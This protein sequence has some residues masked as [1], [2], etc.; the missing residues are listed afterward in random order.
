MLQALP[1]KNGTGITIYG[2]YGDL[3]LLYDT[4]H[5]ISESL[6]LDHS[7]QKGQHQLLMNFAYEV[8]K[9][10]S[11]QRLTDNITFEGDDQKLTHYGFNIV[12]TDILIF[13]S[14]LRYNAGYSRTEKPHQAMLYLLEYSV[15]QALYE[16][17]STGA[18]LIKDYI[19]QRINVMNEYVFIIYQAIHIKFVSDK[20]GVIR[21]RKIPAL[22]GSHFSEWSQV[23]KDLIKSF[24]KSAKERNCKIN[25]LEFSEFPEI[26]W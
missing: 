25:E 11:G 26:V 5:H 1:T 16:Y 6:N 9:A 14:A 23:Y 12:W 24:E 8:R 7:F 15:E 17:D 2:D 19:A 22:I 20:P 3:K 21:F 13:I 18:S 4:A 10:Y